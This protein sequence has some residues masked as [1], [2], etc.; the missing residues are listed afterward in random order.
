MAMQPE[1]SYRYVLFASIVARFMNKV[2][3]DVLVLIDEA[4]IEFVTTTETASALP[5]LKEFTNMGLMRTFS[6]AYGLA[7]YRVGYLV[8]SPELVNYVQA[9]RLPY[10]LNSVSQV[11]AEAAL[12][13]KPLL[14]MLWQPM[15]RLVKAGKLAR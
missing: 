12:W 11:A 5:L 6:K 3:Q 13:I 4:Y 15:L 2:P 10:N 8:L 9:I 7:N 1:Q 14:R